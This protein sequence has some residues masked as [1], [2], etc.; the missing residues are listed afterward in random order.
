MKTS[1]V[2]SSDLL[3]S[4]IS[5]PPLALG[6]D[7]TPDEDENRKI[8]D[9]M[10]SGGVSTFL[11]GGNA[12][13]YN[14]GLSGF[15]GLLDLLETIAPEDAWMIPSVGADFGKAMDQVAVLKGRNFPTAMVLPLAFPATASGVATGLRRIAEA[16]GRPVIAY[17]KSEGYLAPKDLAALLA[18]G[19]VCSVKYAVV[20]ENPSVDDYLRALVEAAG[21]ELLV[22]G[23]GER[24]AITHLMEF[25]LTGFTSGSVCIAPRLSTS[26]LRCLQAGKTELA[27][28]IRQKF[29]S[30]EDLRDGISPLRVLHTAV[31]Q[32]G[33]AR[34]GPLSPF[35]SVLEDSE[36]IERIGRVVTELKTT[37]LGA[38]AEAL[39][40]AG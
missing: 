38:R 12:N 31:E 18:D 37:D 40:P 2:D 5:V 30:L 34:T 21:T 11:Y 32:A 23:I 6:Q 4:V 24:P 7:L 8:V 35:L 33:I 1:A 17:I 15:G 16:Y 19:V 36:T 9:W 22:S 26:L 3:R 29:L 20:R 10:S 39:T 13:L 27:E 28:E 14:L 25:G